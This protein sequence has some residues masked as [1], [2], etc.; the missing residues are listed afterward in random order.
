MSQR[1]LKLVLPPPLVPWREDG[2]DVEEQQ[3]DDDDARR[4]GRWHSSRWRRW[5]RSDKATTI[6]SGGR[7]QINRSRH[8]RCLRH[9]AT[10]QGGSEIK[11]VTGGGQIR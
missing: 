5:P 6:D 11:E 8:Q 7:Q 4:S 3:K 2:D 10:D 1:I 9:L